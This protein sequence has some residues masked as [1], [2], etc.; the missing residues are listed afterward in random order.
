MISTIT[1][2]SNAQVK[3]WVKLSSSS[4]LRYESKS[5]IIEGKTLVHE[6]LNLSLVSALLLKEGTAFSTDQDIQTHTHPRKPL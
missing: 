3:N 6:A 2:T 5:C 4:T 1:S